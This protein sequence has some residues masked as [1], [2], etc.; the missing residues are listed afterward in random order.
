MNTQ[1]SYSCTC[2]CKL[3]PSE[4]LP[5]YTIT[6]Q[7]EH[8]EGGRLH[9]HTI[10]LAQVWLY[11]GLVPV[12]FVCA[13]T[14]VIAWGFCLVLLYVHV[15]TWH[16]YLWIQGHLLE[17]PMWYPC[18]W[19]FERKE[20]NAFCYKLDISTSECPIPKIE[21]LRCYNFGKNIKTILSL[22]GYTC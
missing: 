10:I 12:A 13:D 6:T 4:F 18:T 20:K 15:S 9:V 19:K 3:L 14:R 2:T 21:P 11:L 16:S 5:L 8:R 17:A 7:R 22:P 1:W